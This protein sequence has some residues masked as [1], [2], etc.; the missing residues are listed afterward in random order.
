LAHALALRPGSL[1]AWGD[2]MSGQLGNGTIVAD[3]ATPVRVDRRTD[4]VTQI[5]AGSLHSLAR[6]ADG[7]IW[8]W[9]RNDQGQLGIGVVDDWNAPGRNVPIHVATPGVT[10]V[11]AG[12]GTSLAVL[13]DGGL[14]MWGRDYFGTLGD[15]T[16]NS[17]PNPVPTRVPA[18]TGVLHA[19]VGG[20]NTLATAD[21]VVVP[22]VVGDIEVTAVWRLQAA[23]LVVHVVRPFDHPICDRVGQVVGQGPSAGRVVRPGAT[24]VIEVPKPPPAG[25]F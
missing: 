22:N 10:Q 7:S 13:A 24:V 2:N 11:S 20:Q 6:D 23:G 12:A 19:S 25:C 3:S 17:Q 16:R 8:V 1:W 4:R 21:G 15:G 14:L 9:G 5:D 18:M